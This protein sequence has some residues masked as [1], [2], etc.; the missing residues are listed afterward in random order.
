MQNDACNSELLSVKD[1]LFYL[2]Y[3]FGLFFGK[4]TN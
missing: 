1:V 4:E 2:Q 3:A